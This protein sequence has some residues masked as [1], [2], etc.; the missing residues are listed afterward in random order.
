MRR[1]GDPEEDL[2]GLLRQG[3][4]LLA[5]RP[6][7][8][9]EPARARR[10]PLRVV[11]LRG[12]R[13]ELEPVAPRRLRVVGGIPRR[14]QVRDGQEAGPAQRRPHAREHAAGRRAPG[15]AGRIP[16]HRPPVQVPAHVG[17][18]VVHEDAVP[19][20]RAHVCEHV[21]HPLRLVG[22]VAH[23]HDPRLRVAGRVEPVA[24]GVGQEPVGMVLVCVAVADAGRLVREGRSRS[25]SRTRR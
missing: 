20:A 19:A 10:A 1:V 3:L 23:V 8:A 4:E 18:G 13:D 14:V 11:L 16:R 15:R 17:V 25:G 5:E 24:G 21:G 12:A 7:A 22:R 2:P 9:G 6:V